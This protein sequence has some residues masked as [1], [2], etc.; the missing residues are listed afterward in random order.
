MHIDLLNSTDALY[1]CV[2]II[3][4]VW[5]KPK[6]R[7]KKCRRNVRGPVTSSHQ[8]KM[9]RLAEGDDGMFLYHSSKGK[10]PE[11]ILET[12]I[13][14]SREMLTKKSKHYSCKCRGL[15]C[16]KN[17]SKLLHTIQWKH[18][19]ITITLCSYFGNIAL[20]L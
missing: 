1:I 9:E 15:R 10:I 3:A 12:M 16:Y 14:G 13:I 8:V 5:P 20:I 18:L 11:P 2:D 7:N 19:P 6:Y 4:R 17:Y